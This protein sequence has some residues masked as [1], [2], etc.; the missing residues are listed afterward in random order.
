MMTPS[1]RPAFQIGLYLTTNPSWR[2]K[3]LRM[4]TLWIYIQP[5]CVFLSDY[6]VC[7]IQLIFDLPIII[8]L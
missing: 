7:Q 1:L 3:I 6:I 2:S 8:A 5:R 4:P